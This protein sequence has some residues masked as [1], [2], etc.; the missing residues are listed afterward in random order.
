MHNER[1]LV[2]ALITKIRGGGYCCYVLT[3][4]REREQLVHQMSG[5]FCHLLIMFKYQSPSIEQV[6]AKSQ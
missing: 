4:E 5:L 6:R 2:R 1:Q 3:R